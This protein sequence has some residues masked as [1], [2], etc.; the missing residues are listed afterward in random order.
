M[1]NETAK[2]TLALEPIGGKVAINGVE[3]G[4]FIESI[5]VKAAG[6]QP[7]Q[8]KLTLG[9]IEVSAEV[10]AALKNIKIEKLQFPEPEKPKTVRTADGRELAV[11]DRR[12]S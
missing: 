8:V 12:A 7:T 10:E 4:G 11:R 9:P 2:L 1:D 6:G 5:E 3:I